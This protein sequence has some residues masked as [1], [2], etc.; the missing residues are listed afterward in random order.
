[1]AR[2]NGS[3]SRKPTPESARARVWAAMRILRQFTIP[4]LIASA[5][6]E[7]HN[8]QRFCFGLARTG[9]LRIVRPR[10]SGVKAA[11]TVYS[12]VNDSGPFAPRL[13]RDGSIFD[14]NVAER[15]AA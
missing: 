2:R 14:A 3:I 8:V 5:E 13:H 9:Y 10:V 11:S 6:A 7:R 12:L 15:G 1:M 4:D